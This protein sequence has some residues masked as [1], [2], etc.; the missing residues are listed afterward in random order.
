MTGDDPLH[1]IDDEI[2]RLEDRR[3]EVEAMIRRQGFS[4]Q[5]DQLLQHLANLDRT[6]TALRQQRA[7]RFS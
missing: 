1:R 3:A 4:V 6:L 7:R 5:K 2:S